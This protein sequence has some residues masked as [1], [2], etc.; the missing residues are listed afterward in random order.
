[1][2]TTKYIRH[3][4]FGFTLWDAISS[5][6]HVQMATAMGWLLADLHSAGFVAFHG[7]MPLCTGLSGSLGIGVKPGD[8]HALM[9]QLGIAPAPA[10]AGFREG[11]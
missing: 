1:M 9:R 6:T 5:V 7:G 8:S 3:N 2:Q 11:A 4:V 10:R